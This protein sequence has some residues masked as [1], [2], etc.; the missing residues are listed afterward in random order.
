VAVQKIAE[1]PKPWQ[2]V[3]TGGLEVNPESPAAGYQKV[4]VKLNKNQGERGSNLPN[5]ET[6]A[7]VLTE[8]LE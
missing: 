3:D 5:E 7:P 6:K 8:A 1:I 4:F 2:E